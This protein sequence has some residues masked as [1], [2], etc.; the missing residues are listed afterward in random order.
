MYIAA[1]SAQSTFKSRLIIVKVRYLKVE[2]LV[3][4]VRQKEIDLWP[5][6][7][8]VLIAFENH[9]KSLVLQHFVHELYFEFSRQ[10]I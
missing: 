5:L 4:N 3:S 2:T 1:K 6:K 8:Q 7:S 9:S 10:K